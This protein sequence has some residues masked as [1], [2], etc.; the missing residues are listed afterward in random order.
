MENGAH[1]DL[2]YQDCIDM[3]GVTDHAF[4]NQHEIAFERVQSIYSIEA[5]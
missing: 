5:K 3:L 1:C 4:A 2:K